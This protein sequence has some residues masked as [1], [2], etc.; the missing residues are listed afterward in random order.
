MGRLYGL[1]DYRRAVPPRV[2]RPRWGWLTVAV[3]LC[4]PS[5]VGVFVIG[6]AVVHLVYPQ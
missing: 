1:D 3:L 2:W 4:I 6:R 5:W